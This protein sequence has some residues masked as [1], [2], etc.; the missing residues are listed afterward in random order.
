[1]SLLL[2]WLISAVAVAVTAYALP[3]ISVETVWSALAVAVVLALVNVLL[4][5]IMILLT[6]PLTIITLG[7]FTFVIDALLI[8]LTGRL[9]PGFGVANFW[10]ALL[11]SIILTVVNSLF[12]DVARQTNKD[13]EW[14]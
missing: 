3:G 9:V 7:L 12:R 2:R 14:E 11:F 6:L 13:T 4:K 10:W 8:M 1:M 5:P